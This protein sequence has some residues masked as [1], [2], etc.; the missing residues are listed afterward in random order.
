MQQPIIHNYL[1]IKNS[2]RNLTDEEFENI[3]PQLAKEL[4]DIS[5]Y[6]ILSDEILHKN[7]KLLCRM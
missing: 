3:L 2:T 1:G 4:S 5:F 6:P 7:W